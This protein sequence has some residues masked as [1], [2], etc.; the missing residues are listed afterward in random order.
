MR[1][2]HSEFRGVIKEQ[3]GVRQEEEL[4]S[5]QNIMC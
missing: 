2:T 3:V 1:V 5:P 4:H